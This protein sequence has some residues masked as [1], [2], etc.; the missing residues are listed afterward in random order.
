MPGCAD[1]VI[2]GAGAAGLM[3]AI[4]AGRAAEA[5]GVRK[6]IVVL[7]GA[8]KVG[9]KILVAGG[10]RCNVTHERVIPKDYN[11]SSAGSIKKVLSRFGVE[12]TVR[13]FR[14]LGVELKREATGKLFPVTDDAH[15]VL[16]ALLGAV[17]DAGVT[18]HHPCKV[19]GV[20]DDGEG[21]FVV[22]GD[23]GAI[24]AGKV[25]LATGGRALPKSGS[26]GSGYPIVEALGHT[27]TG[28]IA[29]ALVPLVIEGEHFVK[30]LSGIAHDARVE[31]R[32]STGKRLASTTGA[33]LCT[34]FGL[35][36]PA[37]L[38]ISRHLTAARVEDEGAYLTIGFVH[39]RGEEALDAALSELGK[40]T[41][42]RFV[43]ELLPERLAD[44]LCAE[45]GVDPSTKGA[46]LKR[47]ARRA[48]VLA[49][50]GLRVP[51]ARDRGYTHAEVTMGG[52]PMREVDPSTMGSRVR[53]GLYL[54]GEILDVDGRI[55]GFNFQWAWA[56]GMIAG[57]ACVGVD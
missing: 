47:E 8:G 53:E 56:G 29:P 7:D 32:A 42:G 38:D 1:V 33:L 31:V 6:R 17:R 10:G 41:V 13:F 22:R 24:R 16:D 36:G 4:S 44:A 48:L 21:G 37:I 34:H 11:G 25:V 15:T 26:D 28:V 39:D 46:E 18:I 30:G 27:V 3:C 35:S 40:R 50:T 23:W 20:E 12:D 19:R 52:V 2:V 45:V 49:L 5:M 54:I 55:G 51:V 57:R 14:E 9:V 43:R